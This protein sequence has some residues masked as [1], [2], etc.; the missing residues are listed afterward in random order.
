M[1]FRAERVSGGRI[2]RIYSNLS[3][4]KERMVSNMINSNNID[5]SEITPQIHELAQRCVS[6]KR[7]RPYALYKISGQ[8]RPA[9]FER[10]RRFDRAYGNF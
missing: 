6:K 5:F 7:N 4:S 3:V 2:L 10:Q 8:S 9:R 1:R